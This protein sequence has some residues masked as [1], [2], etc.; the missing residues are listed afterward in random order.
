MTSKTRGIVFE[1]E[2]SRD[3][4]PGVATLYDR[5]R[6]GNNGVMTDITWIQLPSGLWSVDHN[7]STGVTHIPGVP[8]LDNLFDNGA[9]L[10]VWIN[11]RS[12]GGG[13]LGAI[14]DKN[15]WGFITRSEAGGA[16]RIQFSHQFTGNDYIAN[17]TTTVVNINT[18]SHVVMTYDNGNVAN[19]AIEYVNAAVVAHGN[20]MPT[21]IRESE[22]GFN[23][24]I[25]K[26]F[27]VARYFDGYIVRP[28]FYNYILT[29][30]Q[31]LKK[32]EAERSLFGV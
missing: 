19:L 24:S 6:Y 14:F 26:H 10:E 29:A 28:C 16:V 2:V 12:D 13:D 30:G 31:I 17:T 3:V 23:L 8:P 1:A 5:S 32:F 7:G 9:T 18:W 22:A 20:N 11:P 25:G 21:G 15:R 27:T 4:E